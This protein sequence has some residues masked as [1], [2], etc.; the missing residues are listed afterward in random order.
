MIKP[1]TWFIDY[2]EDWRLVSE[3]LPHNLASDRP[4]YVPGATYFLP[5]MMT[6][7]QAI[8]QLSQEMDAAGA[9]K[10]RKQREAHPLRST[11][12]SA[13]KNG[14]RTLRSSR[15]TRWW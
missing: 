13:R 8:P 5:M 15:R 3:N 1:M 10:A 4:A 11:W 12:P 2:P 9:L 14:R 6:L 7:Q